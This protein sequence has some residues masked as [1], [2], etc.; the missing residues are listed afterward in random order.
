MP[1]LAKQF[2]NV[3]PELTA[4][5]DFVTKV[6]KEEE[7]GFL[8]TL[9][10]GLKRIDDIVKTDIKNTI[11]K[12]RQVLTVIPEFIDPDY[13]YANFIISINYNKNLT[14]LSASQISNL[15][16][17]ATANYFNNE[18]QQFE[19][20]FYYSQFSENL[21]S[22]NDSVL[23][24]LA[25][26]KLQKRISPVLN[27][28]NAYID[29]NRLRFNNRLHPGELQSTRFF[30]V[31]DGITITARLRDIPSS[32]PPDYN[33]TGTVRLYNVNDDTDL[34]SVGTIN[35]ASG[36]VS[37]TNI[38]PVGFPNNQFDIA[39][40]CGVQ[41]TSYNILAARNQIVVLDDNTEFVSTS[42]LPGLTINVT[43][44]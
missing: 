37:I 7:E 22:I 13:I 18:L 3:F 28:S 6:V 5:L 32:M 21:N 39:I 9:E 1:L 34:G 4:Q 44:V 10:K 41:E 17:T 25:E 24:V 8:R 38:V 43:A 15:A 11:L 36:E 19:K 35:Y 40:T 42:R 30:V 12:E 16:R 29:A 26:L 27:V 23:S 2:E 31:R 33:G 20:P 14:T